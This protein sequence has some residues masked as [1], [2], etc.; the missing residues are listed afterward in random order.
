[1]Y[2]IGFCNQS[3]FIYVHS[4]VTFCSLLGICHSLPEFKLPFMELL[5]LTYELL[6]EAHR[7][8]NPMQ[9]LTIAVNL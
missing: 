8:Q 4:L 2:G 6:H 9:M 3:T 7:T 5:S 1:M